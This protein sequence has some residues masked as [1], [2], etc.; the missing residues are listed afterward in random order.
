MQPG[1]RELLFGINAGFH[2]RGKRPFL[3]EIRSLAGRDHAAAAERR[4][5][6]SIL[7][8]PRECEGEK[9][10]VGGRTEDQHRSGR[11]ASFVLDN[12]CTVV[13]QGFDSVT[14]DQQQGPC[15]S[16]HMPQRL[17]R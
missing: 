6:R 8:D 7:I 13:N 14:A 12:R 10:L 4:H 16:V 9:G 11:C 1:P 17:Q 2:R 5:M 15:A 3:L